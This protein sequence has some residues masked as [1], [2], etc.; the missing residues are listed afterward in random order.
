[1]IM[2]KSCD[3]ITILPKTFQTPTMAPYCKDE[4]KYEIVDKLVDKIQQ[5]K[6]QKLR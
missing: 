2:I 5:I 4:L 1:M 3:L 6:E